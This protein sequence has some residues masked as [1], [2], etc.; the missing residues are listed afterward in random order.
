MAIQTI[1]PYSKRDQKLLA[2]SYGDLARVLYH[3]GRYADAEPLA[4]WALK[5]REPD[6]RVPAKRVFQNL[7]TLALIHMAQ[8]HFNHAEPLLW[9]ALELQEKEIGPNHIQTAATVDEL[10]GVC[11]EQ[12]KFHDAEGLY[13]RALSIYERFNPEENLDL[14]ACADRYSVMLVKWDHLDEASKYRE[15]AAMIRDTVETR[16]AQ[17]RDSRSRPEFQGIKKSAPP[18]TK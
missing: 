3:E 14:A 15:Q 8:D 13:L 7:Y 1:R 9:R 10:A 11:A 4:E 18:L 2:R 5:V 6:P 16:T 17:R 12:R